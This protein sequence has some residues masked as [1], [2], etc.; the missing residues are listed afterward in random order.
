MIT[1]YITWFLVRLFRFPLRTAISES[2]RNFL[3]VGLVPDNYTGLIGNGH[4]ILH[5]NSTE[6]PCHFLSDRKRGLV[7][8]PIAVSTIASKTSV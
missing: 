3:R 2:H 7:C 6:Y 4:I 8:R 5:N 1:E